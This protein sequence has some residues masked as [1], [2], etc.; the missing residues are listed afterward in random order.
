VDNEENAGVIAA[1]DRKSWDFAVSALKM[2]ER[3]T[4]RL[5]VRGTPSKRL[6]DHFRRNDPREDLEDSAIGRR[7]HEHRQ[8]PRGAIGIQI[9]NRLRI[10]IAFATGR[11]TSIILVNADAE[12]SRIIIF[13]FRGMTIPDRDDKQAART[14]H[15]T[16]NPQGGNINRRVAALCS[17]VQNANLIPGTVNS[18]H[19]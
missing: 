8:A 10:R 2:T 17:F 4:H 15:G 14:P 1:A 19:A 12:G 16:P 9:W 13:L 11:A 7:W 3:P 6:V 5:Q 18:A